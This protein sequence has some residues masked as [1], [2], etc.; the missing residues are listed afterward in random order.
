[1]NDSDR[2]LAARKLAALLLVNDAAE[3]QRF[4]KQRL[5]GPEQ[6]IGDEELALV[7]GLLAALADQLDRRDAEGWGRLRAAMLAVT[8]VAQ[9]VA[10][11]PAAE[12]EERQEDDGTWPHKPHRLD[13]PLDTPDDASLPMMAAAPRSPW[14]GWAAPGAAQ[15]ESPPAV[16]GLHP[17]DATRP[18]SVLAG[19]SE[20]MP[21][22]RSAAVVPPHD[23][24][25]TSVIADRA[26]DPDAD[27]WG[28]APSADLTAP[29]SYTSQA[30][31]LA[32]S[33]RDYAAL[34]AER[35]LAPDRDSEIHER[36]DVHGEAARK[37]LDDLFAQ[38]FA[39]SPSLRSVWEQHRLRFLARLRQVRG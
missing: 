37:L 34:C 26:S 39:R 36:Y 12:P 21:F 29:L 33:V 18:I 25:A 9:P 5:R 14:T 3:M 6:E 28:R 17:S 10:A 7:R 27:D 1:M 11:V 32:L 31:S 15:V 22:A 38:R 13:A 8:P 16:A 4:R 24:D 19:D 23:P 35:E 30:H 20:V 2:R